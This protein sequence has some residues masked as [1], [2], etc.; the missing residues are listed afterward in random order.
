MLS[1]ATVAVMV[2]LLASVFWAPDLARSLGSNPVVETP[3]K[4]GVA[5][6]DILVESDGLALTGWWIPAPAPRAVMLFAHG[7][8]SNRTS[9]FL[10]SLEFYRTATELGISV[11]TID[12]RNHGNSPQTDGKLGMGSTEWPDMLAL[13]NWVDATDQSTLPRIGVGLSMGGATLIYA[14]SNGLRLDAAVLVDPLLNT[15]DALKQGGWI[16]YGLPAAVFAPMAWAATEMGDLP[17]SQGDA[18]T[19]AQSLP[20]PLLIMQDPEDPIT[21]LPFAQ[22]LAAH[23]PRV[24]LSVA[25]R[26]TTGD[27]CLLGKGRWGT[28][29]SLFK[30]HRRWAV[31]ELAEF[32]D[33]VVLP[34]VPAAVAP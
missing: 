27:P 6:E 12:L 7:A 30:C 26:V 32:L 22:E 9:W 31:E 28:H 10:P 15:R 33:R 16:A 23:N 14:L 20:L 18:G 5:Y 17:D 19:L 4:V 25:P 24:E 3:A 34:P 29:V 13:S 1:V 8:G 2:W 21:R 11:A